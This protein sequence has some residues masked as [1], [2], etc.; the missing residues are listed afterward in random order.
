AHGKALYYVNESFHDD[1]DIVLMAVKH[2]G[3]V[4]KVASKRLRSDKEIVL[5]AVSCYEQKF[6]RT[7][8]LYYAHKTLKCDKEVVVKAI[9]NNIKASK[10]I[11]TGLKNDADILKLL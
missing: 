8:V 6:Q 3:E 11:C 10:H 4:L 2:R 9:K 7:S 1:R 5:N